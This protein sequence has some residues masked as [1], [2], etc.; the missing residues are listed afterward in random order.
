[1]IAPGVLWVETKTSEQLMH[2]NDTLR[3][4]ASRIVIH[5]LYGHITGLMDRGFIIL[6]INEN[7]TPT[8]NLNQQDT[9]N[10]YELVDQT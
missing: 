8:Q 6:C 10:H 9:S 4:D 3:N 1:M 5:C 2:K 7:R